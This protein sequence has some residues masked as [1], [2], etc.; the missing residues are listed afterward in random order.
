MTRRA[1]HLQAGAEAE[2][3]ARQYL[4]DRGLRCLAR[5]YRCRHGELD[6]V[7]QAGGTVVIVEVRYR[8]RPGPVPPAATVGPA[9]RHRILRAARHFLAHSPR[10]RGCPVR[11]DIVAL[12]GPLPQAKLTWLPAAFDGEGRPV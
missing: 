3:T 1:P 9:K 8:R 7:M 4:E 5:N 12:S 2:A 6:L 11:F 10:L